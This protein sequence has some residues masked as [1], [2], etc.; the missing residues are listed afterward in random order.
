MSVPHHPKIYHIV[1][2]DRLPHIIAAGWLYADARMQAHQGS[3]TTI[4]LP[5][6]KERRLANTL[7]SRPGL[8]VGECVPFYF[9][10]RSVMLY[11][12]WKNNHPELTY[13]GGQELIIHLEADLFNA[14]EYMDRNKQR[15]AFTTS[16]AGSYYFEDYC[17]KADL[18]KI[19]WEIINNDFWQGHREE[20]Q[21]EFL[22]ESRFP[23]SIIGRIGVISEE[24]RQT[25]CLALREA[26]HKPSVVVLPSW[27]Y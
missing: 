23:W 4:G 9:C 12:F 22:A 16:N 27:Y 17:S 11:I 3:G 1:H 5:G 15:W 10:P 20:K 24:M 14:I 19:N 8:H 25:V 7:V 6:I 2:I 26:R 13:H 21:A 18:D